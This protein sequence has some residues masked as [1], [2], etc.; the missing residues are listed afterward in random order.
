MQASKWAD[1]C[2]SGE[3]LMTLVERSLFFLYIKY[4]HIIGDDV[5]N[6]VSR[7]LNGG[8][9]YDFINKIILVLVPSRTYP[10]IQ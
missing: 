9:G 8:I 5:I 3:F 2:K 4:C 7:I 6:N 10:W 1:F